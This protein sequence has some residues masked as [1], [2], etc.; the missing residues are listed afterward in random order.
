MKTTNFS[1]LIVMFLHLSSFTVPSQI[2]E[3]FVATGL[4]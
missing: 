2:L 4:H 1:K 3:V